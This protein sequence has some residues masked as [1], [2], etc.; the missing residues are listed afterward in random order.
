MVTASGARP[1]PYPLSRTP[2]RESLNIRVKRRDP[3]SSFVDDA[4]AIVPVLGFGDGCLSQLRGG[5]PCR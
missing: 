1:P 3:V 5:E 4:P 2:A